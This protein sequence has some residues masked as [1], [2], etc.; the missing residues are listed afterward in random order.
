MAKALN[1]KTPGSS[2]ASAIIYIAL[3]K[4]FDHLCNLLFVKEKNPDLLPTKEGSIKIDFL[5]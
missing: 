3:S 1:L 4:L 2:C 5:G